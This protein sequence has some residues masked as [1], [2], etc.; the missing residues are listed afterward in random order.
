MLVSGHDFE[1]VES[2][3]SKVKFSL[4]F[5]GL[6]SGPFLDYYR[7]DVRYIRRG[8]TSKNFFTAGYGNLNAEIM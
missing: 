5:T 8:S 2:L 4:D 6:N 7:T 1:T 3:I